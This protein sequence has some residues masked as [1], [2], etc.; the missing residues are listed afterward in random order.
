MYEAGKVYD[1]DPAYAEKLMR[2][3]DDSGFPMF[4]R[5]R[6]RVIKPEVVE[7]E[8]PAAPS[9]RDRQPVKAPRTAPTTKAAAVARDPIHIQ[10][11]DAEMAARLAD[12][13]NDSGV[14][15]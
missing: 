15:V 6:T 12:I 4:M 3:T 2:M 5:E 8:R 11:D 1:V 14:K 10:D 13:D 9:A 7:V